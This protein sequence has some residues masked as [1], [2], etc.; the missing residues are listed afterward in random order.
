MYDVV[1]Y[2]LA[3]LIADMPAF[4]IV[5]TVFTAITYF[6][7]GFENS[8]EQFFGFLLTFV[9]NTL[10]AV[11]LGYFISSSIKDGVIAV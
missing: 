4:I 9:M 5:P 8:A 7:I 2:Y 11:S 3:K 1:P 10:C 6:L